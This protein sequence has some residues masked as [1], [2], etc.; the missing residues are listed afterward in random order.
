MFLLIW[1]KTF[2]KIVIPNGLK[3]PLNHGILRGAR[4]ATQNDRYFFKTFFGN[5]DLTNS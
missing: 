5:F 1:K 3:N 4:S 2:S